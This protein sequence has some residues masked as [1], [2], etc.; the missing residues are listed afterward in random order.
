MLETSWWEETKSLQKLMIFCK[1]SKLTFK[2]S[3]TI[4]KVKFQRTSRRWLKLPL[5]LINR[6]WR[7]REK[8]SKTTWLK[9]RNSP[10][11]LRPSKIRGTHASTNLMPIFQASLKKRERIE[12]NTKTHNSPKAL[13]EDQLAS[14]LQVTSQTTSTTWSTSTASTE[15]E[16]TQCWRILDWSTKR[17]ES[18]RRS[19]LLSSDNSQLLPLSRNTKPSKVIKSMRCSPKPSTEP[20]W[21]CL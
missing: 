9:S 8:A 7:N 17:E 18:W 2:W 4:C 15:R 5:T 16:F 14:A 21:T 6:I 19:T 11:K 1:I 12:S 3:T 20:I 10:E 13:L